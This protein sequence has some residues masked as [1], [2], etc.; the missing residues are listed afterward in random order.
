MSI[1]DYVKSLIGEDA[2]SQLPV[3]DLKG[4]TGKTDYLDFVKAEDMSAPLM[5]GTDAFR[6]PFVALR[7]RNNKTGK[8]MA[9]VIFH[10]YTD[11]LSWVSGTNYAD[12]DTCFYDR[13]MIPAYVEYL[14]RLITRKPCG[15]L[16][17]DRTTNVEK[18]EVRTLEDGRSII[19]LF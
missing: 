5:K 7:Y 3:L 19:E 6:R 13:V 18:D 9:I 15:V 14:A 12:E 11:S 16:Q 2:F 8:C 10:R 4:R 1:H 17:Y